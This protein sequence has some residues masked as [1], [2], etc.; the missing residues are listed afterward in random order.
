VN[1][2][3]IIVLATAIAACCLCAVAVAVAAAFFVLVRQAQPAPTPGV[4]R[5]ATAALPTNNTPDPTATPVPLAT[6]APLATVPPPVPTPNTLDVLRSVQLPYNDLRLL[7]MRLRG[8][9]N[10]P[11][12]VSDKPANWPVGAELKFYAGNMDT[13]ATF[14]VT[15]KLIYRTDNVYFFVQD[16]VPVNLADVKTLVDDFQQRI[17][18]TDRAFFGNEPNPGVD[19][20]PHL[21]MLY[22][23][24]LGASLL[25]YQYSSD[26]YSRLAQKYSN[27]KEIFYLNADQTAPGDP[28]LPGTLA[29]EFQHM[30]H[31]LHDPNEDLWLNEGASV[32]AQFIN[33]DTNVGYDYS[34][35]S[36]P[37]VQLNAWSDGVVDTAT[38]AHYGAAFLFLDYFLNRFGSEATRALVADPANGLQSVDD[39]LAARGITDP[40]TGKPVTANDLFADWVIANYVNDPAVGDGRYFY[41]NYPAVPT[42]TGPTGAPDCPSPVQQ[43]AVHQYG[44]DYYNLYC[45]GQVT[46]AFNG[47]TQV[48]IASAMPHSGRLAFWSARGDKI[49]TTLTHEFDL[50]GQTSAT[51]EY[52]AWWD[53]EQ[54]YDYAYVEASTDDGQTWSILRAPSST[55]DDPV[56]NSYGWGYTGESGGG[57]AAQWVQE[58]VDLSA[59]VGKKVLVRFEYVTD[60]GLDL[61]G[62]MIDDIAIPQLNYSE[63]FENG[64]GGWEA[65]GFV[66]MDNVLPQTFAVQVI[67]W[68]AK[69]TVQRMPLDAANTGNLTLDLAPGESLTLVVSGTTPFTTQPANYQFEVK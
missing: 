5:I 30:I 42:V 41:Q 54:D 21:Y 24:G 25:G 32:L 43:A 50:S 58:S 53:I 31:G 66:R 51:L 14:P 57:A 55:Q 29:H 69:V 8:I 18:P 22:A 37:G 59:Y 23:R 15:A 2:N 28:S 1:R 35:A 46:V 33:G 68:G 67:R 20:D 17:Y 38:S 62:L 19:D 6:I 39:V 36:D 16:G 63:D 3:L 40:A 61:A 27:E 52:W 56:G 45:S 34:Y 13:N 64:N 12:T 9:P 48:N 7:A 26:G 65:Q 49:D 44:A 4:I 47:A 60:D 10:I 11:V